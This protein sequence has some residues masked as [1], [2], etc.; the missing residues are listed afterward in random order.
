[1]TNTNLT[2]CVYKKTWLL[3][4]A[5]KQKLSE[6]HDDY[7]VQGISGVDESK[8]IMRG[9]PYG[10][11]AIL[12]K[13]ALSHAVT[14]VPCDNK[15][16][17]AI[18]VKLENDNVL[19]VVCCYMP[20]DNMSR[21]FVEP[22]FMDTCADLQNVIE[23]TRHDDLLI[24]ADWNTDFDRHTAQGLYLKQFM[25]FL[26]MKCS[27]DHAN[28]VKED[29]FY[30]F[31]GNGS[32]CIDYYLMSD[33]L[34]N[35]VLS[36]V[37]L[38]D[39]VNLSPHQPVLLNA[40]IELS[41]ERTEQNVS[42]AAKPVLS[43]HK[44]TEAQLEMYKAKL[45]SCLEN[46]NIPESLVDCNQP[47]CRDERHMLM[48]D[49]LCDDIVQA[50][51]NASDGVIPV[52]KMKK[53]VPRWNEVAKPLKDDALFWNAIWVSCGKPHNGVVCQIRR[54]TR[55]KYHKAV[56]K[57]KKE[58]N[59]NRCEV[60]AEAMIANNNRKFWTEAK[61]FKGRNR[62]SVPNTMDE[63]RGDG[64]VA[65]LF[66][67]KY[68]TLY[69]SV[70][71]DDDKM[72]DL[73]K[74][75]DEMCSECDSYVKV[76]TDM[77]KDAM[78]KVE[79]GKKDGFVGLESDH[80]TNGS[81]MLYQKLCHLITFSFA[82]SHMPE[83]LQAS[84]IVSIP[85]D[86]RGSMI[87]SENYRGICLCSV[88]VKLMDIIMMAT[89]GNSL[90]TSELQF[91]YKPGHSTTMCT[92]VMKEVIQ[93]YKNN[94]SDVYLCF[95]DASKAFD[96]ISYETLF[97]ILIDR[98]FPAPYIRLLMDNYVKQDIRIKWGS[99]LS[100]PFKGSNGV[101]QGGVI[102]PV[103]FTVYMDRLVERLKQCNAGCWVGHKYFGTL[104]YADDIVL[105]SP[106]LS[107]LQ[108]MVNVC[109]EFGKEN[110]INFNAKKSHCMYV[111]KDDTADLSD[112]MLND[113]PLSWKLSAKHVGNIINQ[114]LNDND[115]IQYKMQLF[116]QQLNRLLADFQG[117]RYDILC[118][119]FSKN[120]NSFYG[121]QCWNM[122]SKDIQ[123]LCRAWNRG[124]RRLLQLNYDAHRYILPCILRTDTLET[125]LA[126]RCCKM[127]KSM[128]HS[129]NGHIK[130]LFEHSMYFANSLIRRNLFCI[131]SKYGATTEDV[132]NGRYCDI[133][134]FFV[135][136]QC[137]QSEHIRELLDIR[138]G[139]QYVEGLCKEEVIDIIYVLSSH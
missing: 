117:A 93:H 27:W 75:V 110:S 119:L 37:V 118:E 50:C 81:D 71:Y 82:H 28:S 103:L 123:T 108:K 8:D 1:M 17:F 65:E 19:L 95:L 18:T 54:S 61:K 42:A 125:Q 26:D 129:K 98:K 7:D 11:C 66:A 136:E 34:Y 120:C 21:T 79:A 4:N 78:R 101:R 126:R 60:M 20:N 134:D 88:I 116:F 52:V 57:L 38:W 72:I 35:G 30:A 14:E 5:V 12:W 43:W 112:I 89:C 107:G 41:Y 16:V 131:N 104:I 114:S 22:Q 121:S 46:I 94:D 80:L 53:G 87:V 39:G 10:G 29:T 58:E 102:S 49:N 31:N 92:T 77:L 135:D 105:I 139:N 25:E 47:G 45:D 122:R 137:R 62:V 9:R 23:S 55:A 111:G 106:S 99:T 133:T 69:N 128:A 124:V 91:A 68:E 97:G 113:K 130:F 63:A 3:S 86:C 70:P 32:S 48:I 115:D 138:D 56:K 51:L 6:I 90:D 76:S 127:Y 96:R 64:N 84:T 85:K 73:C 109:G 2:C 59:L 40:S 13:K 15:R 36:S 74:R 100:K 44:A 33:G 83:C 132:L 67:R 24:A